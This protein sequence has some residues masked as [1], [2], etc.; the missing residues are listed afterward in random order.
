MSNDKNPAYGFEF[1]SEE[2][3]LLLRCIFG[4]DKLVVRICVFKLEQ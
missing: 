4:D 1:Y 2:R 3:E